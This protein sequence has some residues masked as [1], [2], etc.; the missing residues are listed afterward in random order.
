MLQLI[1]IVVVM[2]F[3]FYLSY[4]FS[5]YMSK[6]ALKINAAKHMKVIDKL[7]VGQDRYILIVKIT[8]K[9][10]LI[11][12][13]GQSVQILQELDGDGLDESGDE[14][15]KIIDIDAFKSI[16]QGFMGKKKQ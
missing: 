5:R 11:S 1:V 15:G 8:D 16:F 2:A 3:V 13:T 6:G 7:A 4:L 12:A 9:F 14:S 10:F